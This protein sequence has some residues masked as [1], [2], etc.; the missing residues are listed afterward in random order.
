MG[1]IRKIANIQ[2]ELLKKGAS[3]LK[4]GGILVYSTCTI[5][6][7]EN[8]DIVKRFLNEHNNF[9]CVNLTNIISKDLLD[10]NGCIQTF[11]H[12]HG[13]D[14]SFAAKLIRNN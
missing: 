8:F 2:L 14:G 11:P 7:E 5:E 4:T 6:Q 1:D 9:S 13:I 12:I 10:E 3:L